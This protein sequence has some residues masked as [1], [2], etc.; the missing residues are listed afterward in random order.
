MYVPA[1]QPAHDPQVCLQGDVFIHESAAIAPGVLLQADPGSQ[2]VIGAGVCIGMG[3]ILHANQGKLEIA[4]GVILGAGVLIIGWASLGSNA[5]IGSATTIL[6][7]SIPRETVIAPGSLIGDSSR[8]GSTIPT[9]DLDNPPAEDSPASSPAK[10]ATST[11]QSSDPWDEQAHAALGDKAQSEATKTATAPSASSPAHQQKVP[12]AI[13]GQV[14][15]HHL[16]VTLM[17]HRQPSEQYP[18]PPSANNSD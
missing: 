2:V 13:Y 6:N 8:S 14:Q 18:N 17:P 4:D 10:I 12:N 7:S 16:L 3:C 5:C 1:L 9:G 15:L 11:P